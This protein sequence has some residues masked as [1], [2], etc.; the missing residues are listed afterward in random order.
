MDIPAKLSGLVLGSTSAH[1]LPG[2]R[3]GIRGLNAAAVQALDFNRNGRR[4][5][6]LLLQ[7]LAEARRDYSISSLQP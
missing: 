7:F 4:F 2:G 6:N 1:F 3:Q 5:V